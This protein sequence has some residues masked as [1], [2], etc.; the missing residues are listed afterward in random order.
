M[1]YTDYQATFTT[2]FV[3]FNQRLDNSRTSFIDYEILR[4]E[5]ILKDFVSEFFAVR[6]VYNNLYEKDIHTDFLQPKVEIIYELIQ[7][8]IED[9]RNCETQVWRTITNLIEKQFNY[10]KQ[11]ENLLTK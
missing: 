7:N 5:E 4:D 1:L 3:E 10:V 2:A 8:N 11:I 9:I 6:K